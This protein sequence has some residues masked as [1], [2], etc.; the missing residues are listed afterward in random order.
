MVFKRFLIWARPGL[1]PSWNYPL[2]RGSGLYLF[3]STAVCLRTGES[4][5]TTGY[6]NHGISAIRSVAAL[7]LLAIGRASDRDV[8]G[9]VALRPR[10]APPL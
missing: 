3:L 4:K 6:P 7:P 5:N 2:F 1:G 8:T 10:V 9:R